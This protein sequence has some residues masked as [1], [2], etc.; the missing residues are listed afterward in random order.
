MHIRPATTEDIPA[1]WRVAK[2]MGQTHEENYF[3]R[4]LEEK[5]S[6]KR[7]IFVAESAA[8]VI[9][10]VQLI[11]QP[12]YPLF[13]RMDIPELQDLNVVPEARRQGIG[14][15][16]V[17]RCEEEAKEKGKDNIGLGVGLHARFGAAQRLYVARGY[18]PDGNGVAYDDKTVTAGELRAVDDLLTLKLVK[19][20]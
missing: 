10:Y 5:S 3:D 16:L 7:E 18:M 2:D 12:L 9:G 15:L 20:L 13:R 14:G 17:A 1:L 8:G 11:W 19:I 6:G 4:C